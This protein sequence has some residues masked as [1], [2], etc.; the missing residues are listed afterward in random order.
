[1]PLKPWDM[2]DPFKRQVNR[3]AD[4]H[5]LLPA[6]EK[7]EDLSLQSEEYQPK[8]IPP[9]PSII[10][11]EESPNEEQIPID[12]QVTPNNHNQKD[13]GNQE[14]NQQTTET[15]ENEN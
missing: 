4:G 13:Q 3:F 7:P 12:L 5:L 8:I 2:L 15:K 6:D 1:M 14:N 9:S 11:K 10:M